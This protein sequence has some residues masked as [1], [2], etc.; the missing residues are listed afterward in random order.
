M[1]QSFF[2]HVTSFKCPFFFEKFSFKFKS[3][4]E[5]CESREM[6]DQ[7][8]P[9]CKPVSPDLLS[10]VYYTPVCPVELEAYLELLS[11]PLASY[12][13]WS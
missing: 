2:G 9:R 12:E 6:K 1:M 11:K 4:L 13:D 10:S 7:I 5:D 8:F 3:M